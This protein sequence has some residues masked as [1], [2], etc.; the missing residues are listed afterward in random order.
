MDENRVCG[1]LD[2]GDS[3]F[4]YLIFEI[5]ICVLYI[6]LDAFREEVNLDKMN[7]IEIGA[8]VIAGYLSI[9][10]LSSCEF[11][12]ILD[13]IKARIAQSLMN[14]C[15][16]NRLMSN[17]A[18]VLVTQQNAWSLLC[19][20]NEETHSSIYKKWNEIL[21]GSYDIQID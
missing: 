3:S 16:A 4:S 11:Y 2:F 20:L 10:K 5:A 21:I 14:G 17:N 19:I 18:Y 13:C 7:Q 8:H 1:I 9:L 6:M 12:L 15:Y